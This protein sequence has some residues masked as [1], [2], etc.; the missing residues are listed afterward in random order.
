MS[1][2]PLKLPAPPDSYSKLYE[3]QANRALEQADEGNQKKYQDI[4]IFGRRLQIADSAGVLWTL[5]ATLDGR[6]YLYSENGA[7]YD[8]ATEDAVLSASGTVT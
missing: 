6:L 3:S 4:V 8:T 1:Q 7:I 5:G 2:L